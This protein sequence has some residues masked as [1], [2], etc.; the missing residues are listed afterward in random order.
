MVLTVFLSKRETRSHCQYLQTAK[1]QQIGH[2]VTFSEK[3]G[4]KLSQFF[5]FLFLPHSLIPPPFFFSFLILNQGILAEWTS[6]SNKAL[7]NFI[8]L[9]SPWR[10]AVQE[11]SMWAGNTITPANE[12]VR[13]WWVWFSPI[14]SNHRCFSS[15]S[16]RFHCSKA[17]HIF[18]EYMFCSH[19]FASQ[20]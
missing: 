18:R 14:L 3:R 17:H 2:H 8:Y 9:V 12:S 15:F 5:L 16:G 19:L 11:D 6:G 4:R 10:M 1:L 20:V 13:K 7:E